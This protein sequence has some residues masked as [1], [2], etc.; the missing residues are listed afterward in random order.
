MNRFKPTRV[1][2]II[3]ACLVAFGPLSIDMYLPALPTIA[4]DLVTTGSSVK[5]TIT[6]FL[7]GFSFGML[8]Y[9]PLSDKYG[10]KGLLV[11]GIGLYLIATLVIVFTKSIES[12]ILMRFIQALGGA[13]A[14]VLARAIVRDL[15]HIN[16]AAK[17]LSWM[18]IVT[19]IATLIAPL[20]GSFLL[21]WFN[22][23]A[24]FWFLLLFAAICLV[25]YSL[26][27]PETLPKQARLTSFSSVAVGY[28]N[29]LK[30]Q[31]ALSYIVCMS[32]AFAGMFIYITASAFVFIG[33][34]GLTEQEYAI[35]FATNIGGIMAMTF[36]NAIL[37]SKL[38]PLKMMQICVMLLFLSSVSLLVFSLFYINL[39][40]IMVS[41][42]GFVAMTGSISANCIALLMGLFA[43]NAGTASG[44]AISA[45]FG[46]GALGSFLV[47]QFNTIEPWPMAFLMLIM[48][49]L[50]LVSMIIARHYTL[51]LT[52]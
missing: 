10:R 22:W 8:I 2:V 13:S 21:T 52:I 43:K 5:Q 20:L 9:G 36:I 47:T 14:S 33:F 38:G 26:L 1:V 16:D 29:V 6:L 32:S 27:I 23:Q 44:L 31:R 49:S 40:G 15:Y 45:Q 37:V 30:S 35:L 39:V 11:F 48:G 42:W 34:F 19:L 7:V 12:L 24:I 18:Q 25:L 51:K 41:I 4:T 50:C 46:I 28:L 3:L 17:I